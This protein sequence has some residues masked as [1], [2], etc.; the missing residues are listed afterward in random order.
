MNKRS[1]RFPRIKKRSV[2]M[3]ALA[4]GMAAAVAGTQVSR[5]AVSTEPAA[6]RPDQGAQGQRPLPDG[7]N[8][9]RTDVAGATGDIVAR[10]NGVVDVDG[11]LT[12]LRTEGVGRITRMVVKAGQDVTAGDVLLTLDATRADLALGLA[13][14]QHALAREEASAD[15]AALPAARQRVERFSVAFKHGGIERQKLE[16]AQADLRRLQRNAT[17]SRLNAALAAQHL[18]IAE[19]DVAQTVVRAPFAAK[20]LRTHVSEG[21]TINGVSQTV[22]TLLPE[23]TRLVRAEVNEYFID[24]VREGMR[25]SVTLDGDTGHTSI[26]VE[27]AHIDVAYRDSMLTQAAE[28][29]ARRVVEAVMYLPE[30]TTLRIGQNVKVSFYD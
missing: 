30:T 1:S 28:G 19:F 18:A 26:W 5:D 16:D 23:R 4:I 11:G 20:V 24:R 27:V 10:A 14:T 17:A 7:P 8:L 2:A 29:G 25:A 9:L 15:A 3:L 21:E 12:P 22:I 6:A 13:R